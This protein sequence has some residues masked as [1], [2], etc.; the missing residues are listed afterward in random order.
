MALVKFN[1]KNHS[2]ASVWVVA[3]YD[4]DRHYGGP[5]EGGWYYNSRV[6]VAV[7]TV[8][9][10]EDGAMDVVRELEEGEF[11]S[12]GDRHDVNYP[13][14]GHYAMYVIAPGEPIVH[15]DPVERPVWS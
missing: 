7:A 4:T 3:V 11:R 9:A 12:T 15:R 2:M 5:E 13:G 14:T 10:G 6:L 1:G 8:E